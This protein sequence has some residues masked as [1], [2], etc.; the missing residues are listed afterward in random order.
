[1]D[2]CLRGNDT[3]E[4]I[5]WHR[6]YQEYVYIIISP[7]LHRRAVVHVT[8]EAGGTV[9]VIVA[10]VEGLEGVIADDGGKVAVQPAA[11]A[12]A[13]LNRRK[14]PLPALDAGI[15][16]EAVL[17]KD[18]AAAG[19]EDAADFHEHAVDVG[20][21]AQGPGADDAVAGGV[22]HGDIVSAA[23]A[24]IHRKGGGGDPVHCANEHAGVD[25]YGG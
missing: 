22:G 8:A 2:P 18:K 10:D 1:M 14:P 12:Y 21:A 6:D 4:V 15:V 25:V 24:H 7:S 9:A 11:T 20:N 19:I 13:L 17:E 5:R 16:A 23:Y 3:L